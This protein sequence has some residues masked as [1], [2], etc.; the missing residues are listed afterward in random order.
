MHRFF[1]DQVIYRIAFWV[2][3]AVFV[4]TALPGYGFSKSAPQS[5]DRSAVV[6]IS[7]KTADTVLVVERHFAVTESTTIIN[8]KGKKIPLSNLAVPCNAD[9]DYRLRMD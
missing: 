9:I 2:I 1:K 3:V 6:T 8:I 4:I 5:L 7:G